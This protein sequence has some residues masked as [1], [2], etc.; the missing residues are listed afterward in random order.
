M[1]F[2]LN[3]VVKILFFFLIHGYKIVF[4]EDILTSL[5]FFFSESLLNCGFY[6]AERRDIGWFFRIVGFIKDNIIIRIKE[7]L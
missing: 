7:L 3:S 1:Q 5:V 4:V 2:S 6:S